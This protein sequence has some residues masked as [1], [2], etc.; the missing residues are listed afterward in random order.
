MR[1]LRRST[2]LPLAALALTGSASA[3]S[4]PVDFDVSGAQTALHGRFGRAVA[5]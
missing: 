4:T 5:G 2:V 1:T 3:Q